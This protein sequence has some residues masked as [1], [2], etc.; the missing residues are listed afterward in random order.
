MRARMSLS[1]W[2]VRLHR[3]IDLARPGRNDGRG[4]VL[5]KTVATHTRSAVRVGLVRSVRITGAAQT[6]DGREARAVRVWD[7]PRD[8]TAPALSSAVLPRGNDLR[9][10]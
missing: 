8:R 3:R 6:P 2:P 4:P 1:R 5:T 7:C 10:L 9:H